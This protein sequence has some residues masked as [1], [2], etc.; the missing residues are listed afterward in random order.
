MHRAFVAVGSV[1]NVLSPKLSNESV[2][3]LIWNSFAMSVDMRF[4]SYYFCV[5]LCFLFLYSCVM[6]ILLFV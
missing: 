2:R 3:E 6:C 4:E 1:Y 5:V